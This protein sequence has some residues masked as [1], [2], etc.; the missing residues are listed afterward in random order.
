MMKCE[1]YSVRLRESYKKK[2]R[3]QWKIMHPPHFDHHKIKIVI[4]EAMAIPLS[5]EILKLPGPFNPW[6]FG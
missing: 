4:S 2:R 1:S 5:H 6:R 3:K